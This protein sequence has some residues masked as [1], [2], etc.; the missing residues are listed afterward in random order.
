MEPADLRRWREVQ[1]IGAREVA[2]R[3]QT[4][5]VHVRVVGVC[6][7]TEEEYV[8]PER[9]CGRIVVGL[10]PTNDVPVGIS[11]LRPAVRTSIV[12]ATGNGSI[13]G[14]A[15]FGFELFV[16]VMYTAPVSG[17]TPAHSGRSIRV[18]PA[19]SAAKRALIRTSA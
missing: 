10:E 17:S 2:L 8:P 16:S 5:Y 19:A 1:A 6:A 3:G 4:R 11:P 13:N 15:A 9:R 14:R 18:P 7:C 12:V